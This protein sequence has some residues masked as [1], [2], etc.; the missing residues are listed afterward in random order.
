[1]PRRAKICQSIFQ[2]LA[3]LEHARVFQHRLER[4]ERVLFRDLVRRKLRL[5]REQ[6]AAALLPPSRWPS[7]T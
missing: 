3:D 6:V 2:V 1:M 4:G 5:R 7:G